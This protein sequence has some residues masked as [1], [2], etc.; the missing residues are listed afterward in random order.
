MEIVD[1]RDVVLILFDFMIGNYVYDNKNTQLQN[2]CGYGITGL[3]LHSHSV[4]LMS[5]TDAQKPAFN[6]CNMKWYNTYG[7]SKFILV[8]K[9]K[10]H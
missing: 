1:F 5:P 2:F 9:S 7:F 6:Y 4:Q 8:Y 3:I 10:Y